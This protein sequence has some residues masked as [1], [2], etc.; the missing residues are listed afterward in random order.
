MLFDA[1]ANC[2]SKRDLTFDM[3][4]GPKGAKRPLERPLD[5]RVRCPLPATGKDLL[6][7]PGCRA[8]SLLDAHGAHATS[9]REVRLRVQPASGNGFEPASRRAC[10]TEDGQA[11]KNR[12]ANNRTGASLSKQEGPARFTVQRTAPAVSRPPT[13]G[14]PRPPY[15]GFACVEADR[16]ARCATEPCW[17][18]SR[19]P[20]E[21]N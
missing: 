12:G 8:G 6:A 3:S 16:Q 13:D 14:R 1:P 9:L 19:P 17:R 15:P 20:V 7:A 10:G 21:L 11:T 2:T 18:C 4:G 5:G